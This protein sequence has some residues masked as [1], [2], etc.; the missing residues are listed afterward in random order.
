[1]SEYKEISR[2][3]LIKLN[4]DY[5]K[6]NDNSLHKFLNEPGREYEEIRPFEQI[7][8]RLDEVAMV[9][10]D[11]TDAV[12]Q[13]MMNRVNHVFDNVVNAITDEVERCESILEEQEDDES[14]PDD[15]DDDDKDDEE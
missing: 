11:K 6:A 7:S 2:R 3:G 12:S 10:E 9:F 15:I 1:M 8:E 5:D 14:Y 4:T 13:A